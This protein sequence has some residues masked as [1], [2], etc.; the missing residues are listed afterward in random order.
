MIKA[1]LMNPWCLLL[2]N[3]SHPA[4][5]ACTDSAGRMLLCYLPAAPS[6]VCV[7]V[8]LLVKVWDVKWLTTVGTSLGTCVWTGGPAGARGWWWGYGNSGAGSVARQRRVSVWC[9]SIWLSDSLSVLLDPSR[10]GKLA[11][12]LFEKC[13]WT[14]PVG[15][16]SLSNSRSLSLSHAQMLL[17]Q[18]SHTVSNFCTSE[19]LSPV[20]W[21]D[22]SQSCVAF[23]TPCSPGGFCSSPVVSINKL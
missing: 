4:E 3:I 8:S 5:S 6:C 12:F 10:T 9:V 2:S 20:C 14:Q 17:S 13:D 21:V 23:Q 15:P 7:C 16:L 19:G 22:R 1:M 11:V 18:P